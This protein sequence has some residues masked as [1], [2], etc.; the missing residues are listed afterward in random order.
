PVIGLWKPKA[1]LDAYCGV[2]DWTWHD[3]RRTCDTG[4]AKL[5]VPPHIREAVLNHVRTGTE[6]RHYNR[7]DYLAEKREALE[8]WAQHVMAAVERYP[9][10]LTEAE[11]EAE[12][13]REHILAAL[14]DDIPDSAEEAFRPFVAL[15]GK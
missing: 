4:L 14:G 13:R 12:L 1:R 8:A 5:R 15:T 10:P 2:T 11:T 7:Y 3:L 9:R 6:A